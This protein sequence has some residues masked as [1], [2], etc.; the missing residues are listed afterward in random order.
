MFVSVENG[1]LWVSRGSSTHRPTPLHGHGR[2]IVG[3]GAHRGVVTLEEGQILYE[4]D[5]GMIQEKD[6]GLF[7]I[8]SGM[9]REDDSRS[10]RTNTRTG[11]SFYGSILAKGNDITLRG[12]HA[13]LD[14]AAQRGAWTKHTG[15]E[16]DFHQT[17]NLRISTAGPGWILG[18]N[19][20]A[21]GQNSLKKSK[22]ITKVKM[23]HLRFSDLTKIEEDNP[24][25]VLRLY[26]MLTHVMARKG[27]IPYLIFRH[28]TIS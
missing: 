10:N 26:K 2:W 4:R 23:H 18:A 28:F 3:I 25:L 22:A 5:G 9:I 20:L 27:K 21:M 24:A 11:G 6:H 13:R 15:R 17:N 1:K 7:F 19:A 12:R 16:T 8:E 14:T